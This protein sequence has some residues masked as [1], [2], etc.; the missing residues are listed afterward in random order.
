VLAQDVEQRGSGRRGAQGLPPLTREPV[1]ERL[2]TSYS[3]AM[4]DQRF[5]SHTSP[6]GEV[7]RQRLDSY[8]GTAQTWDIGENLAWGE[9][10]LATP[11]GIVTGWMNSPGHRANILNANF[12]EIGIGV[13]AGTPVGSAP[14][15]SATFTT[16]FGSRVLPATAAPAAPAGPAGTAGS[17]APG[18]QGSKSAPT[19]A[20]AASTTTASPK[21]AAKR[22]SAATKRR[23][24]AQCSRVARRSKGSR[25]ARKARADRC[26]RAK[27]RT[28]ARG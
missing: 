6:S 21:P 2:A 16:E 14:N 22:V 5:F 7:L 19:T 17:A 23:V 20:S 13:V 11:A 3:Q 25:S 18:R 26:V 24:Q 9:G 1:L 8:V 27:L 10:S 4:V 15:D 12:R 28:V